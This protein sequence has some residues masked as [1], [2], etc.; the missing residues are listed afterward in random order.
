MEFLG[1]YEEP[2]TLY[3]AMEYLEEGNLSKNISTLAPLPQETV[4]T[5]SKQILE[6]LK[7]MHQEGITHGDIKP[8]VLALPSSTSLDHVSLQN[9]NECIEHL[10]GFYVSCVGQTRGFW[11]VQMDPGSTYHNHSHP[12]ANFNV[13]CSRDPGIRPQ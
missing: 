6:G 5:I 10:C 9:A 7:V 13:R 2:E 12:S 1:W 11:G 8:A 4:K 3:I